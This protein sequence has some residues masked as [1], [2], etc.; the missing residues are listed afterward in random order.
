MSLSRVVGIC[1]CLSS[2]HS[3]LCGFRHVSS[4]SWFRVEHWIQSRHSRPQLGDSK[5]V[6]QAHPIRVNLRTLLGCG[7]RAKLA[8]SGMCCV[9]GVV[10]VIFASNLVKD[11][12]TQRGGQR[13]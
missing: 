13:K 6:T 11:D 1:D 3:S 8:Y 7:V 9:H 10:T 4:R 2:I 5:H 12:L